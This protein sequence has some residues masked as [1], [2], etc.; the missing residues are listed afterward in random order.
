MIEHE[1]KIPV[2]GLSAVEKTIIALNGEY[3]CCEEH[4]DYFYQHPCRDFKETDEALR[5][6]AVN[7]NEVYLCYKG[8][9]LGID[10]KSR[11]EYEVKVGELNSLKKI[12]EML[13]F[14]HVATV[15]KRRKVY[16][17]NS[18]KVCLDEVADLGEFVEIEAPEGYEHETVKEALIELARKLN[19]PYEKST[20]KSYLEM[21]LEKRKATP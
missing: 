9:K 20:I 6:R 1:L 7:S 5:I 10:L 2:S 21:L 3:L 18:F 16:R 14:K 19:L 8:P 15:M 17:L 11:V 13:G 4:Y 12:L